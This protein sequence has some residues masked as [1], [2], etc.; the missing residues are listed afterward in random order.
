MA[1]LRLGLRVVIGAH[2]VLAEPVQVGLLAQP[3]RRTRPPGSLPGQPFNTTLVKKSQQANGASERRRTLL[4]RTRV[5]KLYAA[6]EDS[7]PSSRDVSSTP[8]TATKNN[9]PPNSTLVMTVLVLLTS[10]SRKPCTLRSPP[11]C[12][13]STEST[14][15]VVLL[16]SILLPRTRA[17]RATGVA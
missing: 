6:Y 11:V 8:M 10:P 5:N 4:P 15:P 9:V 17:K 1:T 13:R 16:P 7:S 14:P 2:Q 12:F 3:W